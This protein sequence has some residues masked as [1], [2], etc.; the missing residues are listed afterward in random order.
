MNVFIK[1]KEKDHV[2]PSEEN[3]FVIISLTLVTKG[4]LNN[5]VFWRTVKGFLTSKGCLSINDIMVVDKDKV[6]REKILASTKP[7][8]LLHSRNNFPNIERKHH[9]SIF[10]TKIKCVLIN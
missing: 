4:I 7:N 5:K 6:I 3:V 8:L 9:P 2:Y 1:T 10:R